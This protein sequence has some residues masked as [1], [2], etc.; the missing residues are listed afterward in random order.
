MKSLHWASELTREFFHSSV[1]LAQG[2]VPS[3]K[4]IPIELG[5]MR[6]A[7]GLAAHLAKCM[8]TAKSRMPRGRFQHRYGTKTDSV[9]PFSNIL[10]V[11]TFARDALFETLAFIGAS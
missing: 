2:P 3:E 1:R 7:E 9:L 11:T 5:K 4:I 6:L 8:P 10:K